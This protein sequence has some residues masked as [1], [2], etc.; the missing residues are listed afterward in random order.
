MKID[1]TE[2]MRLKGRLVDI[3][4]ELDTILNGIRS[5]FDSI[6]SNIGSTELHQAILNIQDKIKTLGT[7]F[8]SDMISLENFLEEQLHSY[9][10]TNEEASNALK[11]LVTML[12]NVFGENGEILV[13][14]ASASALS[15]N[16][17]RKA[18]KNIGDQDGYEKGEKSLE[19]FKNKIGNSE[20]KWEVVHE[21]YYF[22]KE[23]GLS[24]EQI[25]GIIGNMTQES[26][27][28][29]RCPTGQFEGLFQWSNSRKPESF[30]LQT[31]LEHAW[32]EI[33]YDRYSGKVLSKL[34]ETQ[35]V[36]DATYSFA[37]WFEGYTGEMD[38]RQSF[39]NAVYYYIKQNL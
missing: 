5:D 38:L 32:Q 26:A 30:D 27:L 31:Q 6:A 17:G 12:Q 20:E 8:S 18:D 7:N 35:S 11:N 23:K 24:D 29:L 1:L 9:T 33:E 15:F 4:S 19:E 22:F 10:V 2:V 39:A 14:T 21:T 13:K 25:A 37:K 36:N 16:M 3:N 28:D 34:S